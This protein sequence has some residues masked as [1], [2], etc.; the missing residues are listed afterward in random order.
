[1]RKAQFT[2]EGQFTPTGKSC[3]QAIHADRQF[4]PTG[5]SCRQAIHAD[6]Q[7]MTEGQFTRLVAIHAPIGAFHLPSGEARK[8]T[9]QGAT[10]LERRLEHALTLFK[11]GFEG[12]D[13]RQTRRAK[14]FGRGCTPVHR[15][16]KTRA[17]RS[18]TGCILLQKIT[19]NGPR[20][21]RRPSFANI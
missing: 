16:F 3:R 4:T 20:T 17:E 8:A 7:F 15:N 10:L 13:A 2:T 1:M 11:Y 19:K 18:I 14:G 9:G 21:T 5:N 6:R 12:V